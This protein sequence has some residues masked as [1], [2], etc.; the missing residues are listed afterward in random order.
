MSQSLS[1]H[2]ATGA[3]PGGQPPS[4]LPTAGDIADEIN[5]HLACRRSDLEAEGGADAEGA[6]H[7]SFV[8][9]RKIAR[10]LFW[11]HHGE[12]IMSQWLT[13]AGLVLCLAGLIANLYFLY[14]QGR[15]TAAMNQ[16]ILRLTEQMGR[17]QQPVGE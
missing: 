12:R 17:T 1:P 9:V 5:D 6:A 13:R 11:I 3:A 8:D 14:L 15:N 4:S 2:G 16:A 7:R 10:K